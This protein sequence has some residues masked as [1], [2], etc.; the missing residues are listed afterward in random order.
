MYDK[1]Q[2]K[3]YI[4]LCD[5]NVFRATNL[6]ANLARELANRYDNLILYSEAIHWVLTGEKP[7]ILGEDNKVKYKFRSKKK[8]PHVDILCNIDDPIIK[9][10]VQSSFTKSKKLG[11]LTYVYNNISDEY[12]QARVRI[13]SRMLW[14]K[15]DEERRM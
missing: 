4:D 1:E 5:G 14:Y 7:N 13:L 9:S 6:V 8:L 2:L 12:E 11:H 10:A 15:Y 3:K